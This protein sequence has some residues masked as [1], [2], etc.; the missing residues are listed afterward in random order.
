MTTDRSQGEHRTLGDYLAIARRRKWMVILPLLL[1]PTIGYVYSTQQPKRFAATAEVWISRQNVASSVTGI[2]NPD[3]ETDPSRFTETQADLAR[4]PGVIAGAIERAAIQGVT[5][6]SLADQSSVKPHSNSDILTFKVEDTVPSR[7]A[8][9]VTAYA[10][11]F[12]DYR[13]QLATASLA[14][15][16]ADLDTN[17]QRLREDGLTETQLYRDLEERSHELRTLE[18]LQ[19]RPAVVR[20]AADAEQVAPTPERTALLGLALGLLLGIAAALLWDALDRRVRDESEVED[21]LGIPLLARLSSAHQDGGVVMLSDPSDVEA[22]AVRRLRTSLEFANLD[23][24]A[25]VIMVTSAVASEGKSLALANLAVA[26]ARSGREVALVDLDLRRP[27]VG[28]LFGT[29]IGYGLTD[30]A[31]GRVALDDALVTVPL[32]VGRDAGASSL[33]IARDEELGELFVLTA[34]AVPSNPGELL[35]TSVVRRIVA[36]LR[37]RMDYVLIDAPPMLAVS[38]ASILS[39]LVDAI[40]IVVRLGRV[41]RPSLREL[42][43]ELDASLAPRLGFII[44]GTNPSDFYG[45]YGYSGGADTAEGAKRLRPVAP[46]AHPYAAASEPGDEGESRRWA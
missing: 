39:S 3:V 36:D 19:T 7:A 22:E 14:S 31:L 10:H 24:K 6:R 35:G 33:R 4:V 30:V 34:G 45:A 17:L 28:R 8:R 20:E 21:A 46:A 25:K 18:L 23:L 29:E 38:D 2:S 43:R 27:S 26:L 15:A 9:L 32:K 16:R 11:S 12:S 5:A 40:V 37:E 13:L 41:N 1:V 44:T 42:S